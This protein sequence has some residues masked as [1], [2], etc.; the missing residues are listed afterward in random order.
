MARPDLLSSRF[1]GD[2][3]PEP[4][5][6]YQVILRHVLAGTMRDEACI[7]LLM[8]ASF[9]SEPCVR[10]IQPSSPDAESGEDGPGAAQGP[11]RPILR[12]A[13]RPP[14]GSQAHQ[15]E[16]SRPRWLA[17]PRTTRQVKS[18]PG[19]PRP[20]ALGHSVA[21]ESLRV[22]RGSFCVYRPNPARPVRWEGVT[23]R[24]MFRVPLQR[25]SRRDRK[26]RDDR[27][28]RR[29]RGV[30]RGLAD[31]DHRSPIARRTANRKRRHSA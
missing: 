24:P 5:G 28:G 4:L 6:R 30:R 7:L 20:Q 12:V 17:G 10:C 25:I 9:P 16:P 8:E 27:C 26:R 31:G 14:R 29:D 1:R 23:I 13:V 22:R 2:A 11:R 19:G 18:S 21:G 15:V 3:D